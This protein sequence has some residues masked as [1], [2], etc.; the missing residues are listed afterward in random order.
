MGALLQNECC[1]A[2]GNVMLLALRGLPTGTHAGQQ[3]LHARRVRVE[4]DHD[5][6]GTGLDLH[7]GNAGQLGDDATHGGSTP[8]SSRGLVQHEVHLRAGKLR[9]CGR[10]VTGGEGECGHRRNK[11]GGSVHRRDS[12][13]SLLPREEPATLSGRSHVEAATRRCHLA[14]DPPPT[15]GRR[16]C[17]WDAR[18]NPDLD[19][20]RAPRRTTLPGPSGRRPYHRG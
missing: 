1:F 20:P 5:V 4:A 11:H 9:F 10:G 3:L 15:R 7:A 16:P 18:T 13:P 6:C 8:A 2:C 17:P 12:S 19:S 14:D